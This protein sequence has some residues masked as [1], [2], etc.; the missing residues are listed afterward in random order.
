[1]DPPNV[2][3]FAGYENPGLCQPASLAFT[4]KMEQRVS[5]PDVVPS[6]PPL[7]TAQQ[8]FTLF[9]PGTGLIQSHPAHHMPA[10]QVHPTP[11]VQSTLI[12]GAL[13]S[14]AQLGP[15]SQVATFAHQSGAATSVPVCDPSAPLTVSAHQQNSTSVPVVHPSEVS[16]RGVGAK[17]GNVIANQGAPPDLLPAPSAAVGSHDLLHVITKQMMRSHVEDLTLT[18]TPKGTGGGYGVGLDLDLLQ[19]C[20]ASGSARDNHRG[21]TGYRAMLDSWG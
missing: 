20:G 18:Q 10:T 15:P 17:L 4:D 11:A 1:M 14:T 6:D 12:T 19:P 9:D 2:V 13:P 5:Y 21:M 7:S 8:S 16:A 3:P